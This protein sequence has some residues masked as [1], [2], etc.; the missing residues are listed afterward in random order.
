MG[1]HYRGDIN[2]KFLFAIQSSGAADRFGGVCTEEGLNYYFCE[3]N[4]P[5]IDEEL[6]TIKKNLGKYLQKINKY[7]NEHGFCNDKE[8]ARALDI[9]K[10]QLKY[11][12]SD[13]ADF[14]LGKKIKKCIKEKGKCE[15]E[16]EL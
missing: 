7:Y 13:Y 1:R 14:E 11:Y 6:E 8:M 4:L 16:V 5:Q 9:T 10:E 2:G 12:L 15:F 3:K